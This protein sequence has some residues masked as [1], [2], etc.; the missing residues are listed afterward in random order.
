MKQFRC[1]RCGKVADS[2][3]DGYAENW[4][5]VTVNTA[6]QYDLCEDCGPLLVAF[7]EK[8]MSK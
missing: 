3:D 2:N 5:T 6:D 7:F 8:A 1:D 4:E